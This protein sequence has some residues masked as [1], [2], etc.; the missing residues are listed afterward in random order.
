M[1]F[2]HTLFQCQ[3]KKLSHYRPG[4]VLRAPEVE[5]PRI[6]RQSAHKGVGHCAPAALSQEISV[7]LLSVRCS[8]STIKAM[9]N[10]NEPI[11][12]Q[13]RYLL[14]C[15]APRTPHFLE[16]LLKFNNQSVLK[17]TCVSMLEF[18]IM[19]IKIAYEDAP[20]NFKR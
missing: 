20:V 10:S 13:T 3:V 17:N 11:G 8:A 2:F 12:N 16:K 6:S 19:L 9:K 7:V 18:D 15:R 4:Q 5:A 14:I 1:L